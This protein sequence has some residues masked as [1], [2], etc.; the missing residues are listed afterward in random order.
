MDSLGLNGVQSDVHLLTKNNNKEAGRGGVGWGGG[1][2]GGVE[3]SL[4]S[5][6]KELNSQTVC[7][8]EGQVRRETVEYE[9]TGSYESR[10]AA[11]H[12]RQRLR[13]EVWSRMPMFLPFRSVLG[14]RTFK[15]MS[16]HTFWLSAQALGKNFFIACF[17]LN[18][19][20]YLPC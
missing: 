11:G 12:T 2:G 18:F 8:F 4:W 1:G 10:S 20:N 19:W 7:P 15:K 3:G 9:C 6:I 17:A 13:L 5:W 14:Q 16:L